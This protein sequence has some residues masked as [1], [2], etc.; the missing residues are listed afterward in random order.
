[1]DPVK[2]KVIKDWEEPQKIHD[3]RVFLGLVNYYHKFIEGQS[4]IVA[5]L[6]DL[7]KKEKSWN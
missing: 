6:T 1:M 7:L 2:V 3:V 5:P 4:K